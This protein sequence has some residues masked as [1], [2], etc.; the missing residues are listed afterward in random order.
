MPLQRRTQAPL[1]LWA[2]VRWEQRIRRRGHP[3][4]LDVALLRELTGYGNGLAVGA[5][6]AGSFHTCN[7]HETKCAWSLCSA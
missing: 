6:C 1:F 3:P 2:F 5:L 4:L 7:I